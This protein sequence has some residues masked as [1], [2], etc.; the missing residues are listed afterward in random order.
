MCFSNE[1]DQ[2]KFEKLCTVFRQFQRERQKV[3]DWW[4]IQEQENKRT[5]GR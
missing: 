2:K 4:R 5:Q 3:R 1:N